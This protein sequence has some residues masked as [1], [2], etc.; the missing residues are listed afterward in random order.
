MIR[1]RLNSL[2]FPHDHKPEHWKA[3]DGLRG[4]AILLVVLSHTS[5][6]NLYFHEFLNF[7]RVGKVG[8]YLFFV[9][10]AYLLDRQITQA[11]IKGSVS[12]NYWKNYALRR[13]LRIYPL[14]AIAL[15]FHW[16]LNAVGIKTVINKFLDIP[17]HLLMLKGESIFW[18]IPVE[19]KYYLVS[20][21]LLWFCHSKLKWNKLK[22]LSL[23]I[24]LIAGAVAIELMFSL[25][26]IST[27]KYLPIFL[28]GTIISVFEVLNQKKIFSKF[29][30]TGINIISLLSVLLII[31]S[32]PYYFRSIF[33][34]EV[35]FHQSYFYLPYAIV[36]GLILISVRHGK[37]ILQKILEFK[38]LRF[39]GTISFSMYLFHMPLITLV[40]TSDI[41]KDLQIYVFLIITTLLSMLSYFLIER[42]LSKIYLYR[43]SANN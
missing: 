36:W 16:V 35:D 1:Q 21:L 28:I 43:K 33:N 41:N 29:S 31:I 25:P 12:K 39:I 3:L 32:V 10:S 17:F 8:V 23:F 42:P 37:G 24:L 15:I 34:I 6:A 18:S 20:P 11:Y 9:L 38:L 5:N 4:I 7:K 22:V 19:F 30:S 13:F 2:F 26:R 14:F 27:L 40:K